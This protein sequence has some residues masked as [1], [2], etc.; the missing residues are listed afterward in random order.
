MCLLA[1]MIEVQNSASIR[2]VIAAA[3]HPNYYIIPYMRQPSDGCV[4][5]GLDISAMD[6]QAQ[7]AY[8]RMTAVCFACR[9]GHMLG[10]HECDS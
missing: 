6:R 7:T 4:S 2:S 8:S 1:E 9:I 3:E 10:N 5:M